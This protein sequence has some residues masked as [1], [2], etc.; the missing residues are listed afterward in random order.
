MTKN[1]KNSNQSFA[2][3]LS[4]ESLVYIIKENGELCRI[5]TSSLATLR[6][7]GHS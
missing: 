4:A 6:E 2:D 5:F 3:K 7:D 1:P